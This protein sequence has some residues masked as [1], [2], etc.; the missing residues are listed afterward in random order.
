MTGREEVREAFQMLNAEV[1]QLQ[2]DGHSERAL[3]LAQ[4]VLTFKRVLAKGAEWSKS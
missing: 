2:G 4:C 3:K 1:E